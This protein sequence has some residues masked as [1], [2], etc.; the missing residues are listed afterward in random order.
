MQSWKSYYQAIQPQIC[1]SS[2]NL[3][4]EEYREKLGACWDEADEYKTFENVHFAYAQKRPS[5]L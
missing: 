1:I 2:S 3:T 4:A 5:A